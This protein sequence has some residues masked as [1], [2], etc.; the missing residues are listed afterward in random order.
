MGSITVGSVLGVFALAKIGRFGFGSRKN[1][2]A[3]LRRAVMTVAK[4]LFFGKAA[5][6]PSVL[7]SGFQ[8]DRDGLFGG[9]MRFGHGFLQE[10][11]GNGIRIPKDRPV[12]S[13]IQ[14]RK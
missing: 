13:F 4:G 5:S 3:E 8:L 14:G 7:L 10:S 9:N 6:A 2:R 1:R 12:L 11:M